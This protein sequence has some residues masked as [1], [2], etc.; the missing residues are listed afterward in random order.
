MATRILVLQGHPDPDPGRFGR[1]LSA[2]YADA[3]QSAGH[4]V[5]SVDLGGLDVPLL[6]TAGEWEQ[7]EVPE[8]LRPL[9][10][11]LLWCQHLLLC[12]P[13]WLGDLPAHTKAALEQVLRPGITAPGGD[14]GPGEFK[15]LQGRSAHVVVTMGM[16]GFV[17]RWFYRAHS[18]KSLERNVLRFVGFGPVR[19]TLVGLV[20][21]PSPKMHARWLERMRRAGTE[22]R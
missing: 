7:G 5:R 6:R 10:Q 1:A 20:A 17:Y 8:N 4:E 15:P 21:S 3:A 11:G 12:Y 2:A 22:A 14:R 13:M 18:L 9:Q 16:P 19:H